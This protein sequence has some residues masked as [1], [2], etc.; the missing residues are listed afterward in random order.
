VSHAAE[1]VRHTRKLIGA[2]YA[3]LDSTTDDVVLRRA[4]SSAYYGLF[5]RLTT[6]GSMPFAVGGEPLRFQAARAF[7]HSAMRKVC[8]AYIRSPARPFPPGLEHLSP[9]PPD[10][11]LIE[12]ARAFARLQEGR[13]VANYD[14]SAVNKASYAAELVGFAETA[15]TDFDAIQ[16]LPETTVFLTALL[17]ADRWTRRG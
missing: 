12:I 4:V 15:L 16:F 5:H 1:L 9:S 14:L 7:S 8:D 11:R 2:Q 3:R 6:A 17:L 10:R 13:H